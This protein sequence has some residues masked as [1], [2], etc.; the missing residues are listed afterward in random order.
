M[1]LSP[2]EAVRRA[3]SQ[4][5]KCLVTPLSVHSPSSS[6]TL[7]QRFS[8]SLIKLLPRIQNPNNSNTPT[9]CGEYFELLCDFMSSDPSS[10]GVATKLSEADSRVLATRVMTLLQSSSGRG[11]G[12]ENNI[13]GL[14]RL[15]EVLFPQM[16]DKVC[17]NPLLT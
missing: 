7:M 8:Q 5:W 2:Y 9:S 3:V 4:G 17:P 12:S 6:P 13:L 10:A 14:F 16:H 1:L 15:I 11:Q